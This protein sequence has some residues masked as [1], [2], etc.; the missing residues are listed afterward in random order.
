[1]IR[2]LQKAHSKGL[3]GPPFHTLK[4][5]HLLLTPKHPAGPGRGGIKNI[6]TITSNIQHAHGGTCHMHKHI[7]LNVSAYTHTLLQTPLLCIMTESIGG[8]GTAGILS[9]NGAYQCVR[10]I[11][12]F[13]VM[14]YLHQIICYYKKGP[15]YVVN[16]LTN[17]K[18]F[19]YLL[20]QKPF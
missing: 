5:F 6:S 16:C 18:P 20:P 17:H 10:A 11:Y 8:K 2:I 14:A 15:T 3:L 12:F 4:S 1:M 19:F 9:L 7:F 13:T